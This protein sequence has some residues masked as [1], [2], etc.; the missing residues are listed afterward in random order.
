MRRDRD[1]GRF[2]HRVT[3][4]GLLVLAV[5][6]AAAL[7][8]ASTGSSATGSTAAAAACGTLPKVAGCTSRSRK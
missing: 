3:I 6:I 8:T 7:G 4:G 5:A 1:A 2:P